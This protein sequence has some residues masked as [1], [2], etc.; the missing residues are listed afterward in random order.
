MRRANDEIKK[1]SKERAKFLIGVRRERLK[2]KTKTYREEIK[3]LKEEIK[4]LNVF[5]A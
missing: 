4:S 1:Q 5:L 2:F 3:K